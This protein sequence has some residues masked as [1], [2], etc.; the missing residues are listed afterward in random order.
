MNTWWS[1]S[2]SLCHNFIQPLWPLRH[3]GKPAL[4]SPFPP[5]SS[6]ADK[7]T[8]AQTT[9]TVGKEELWPWTAH[10]K[11]FRGDTLC[12]DTNSPVAGWFSL[13]IGLTTCQMKSS[14]TTTGTSKWQKNPSALPSLPYKWTTQQSI[15][16]L[17]GNTRVTEMTVED[18]QNM[19]WIKTA[20]CSELRKIPWSQTG[21]R[22]ALR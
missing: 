20:T 2:S 17:S 11:P 5:G 19:A 7:V 21:R 8:Q 22:Q 12:T 15:S 10:M 13:F 16:V 18:N 1:F 14:I 9:A 3:F 4:P 6:M